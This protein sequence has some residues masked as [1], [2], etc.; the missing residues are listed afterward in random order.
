LASWDIGPEQ[1]ANSA[2]EAAAN[3]RRLLDTLLDMDFPDLGLLEFNS[4]GSVA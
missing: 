2:T 3:N 4:P 1:A